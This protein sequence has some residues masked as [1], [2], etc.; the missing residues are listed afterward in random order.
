MIEAAAPL[1]SN[2]LPETD[3]LPS[4]ATT[5]G[6]ESLAG[7]PGKPTRGSGPMKGFSLSVGGAALDGVVVVNGSNDAKLSLT[8]RFVVGM[9]GS[10]S[11]C[12]ELNG[13]PGS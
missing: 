8:C 7:F 13:V 2:Q 11:A 4:D 10:V 1:S 9:P 6:V 12:D 5:A 3:L